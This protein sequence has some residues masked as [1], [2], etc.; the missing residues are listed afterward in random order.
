MTTHEL[1]VYRA[2]PSGQIHL[3]HITRQLSPD[4]VL[5]EVTHASASICGTDSIYLH[6]QQALGHEG[7][8]IVRA[9]GAD[10]RSVRIGDRVGMGYVQKTCGECQSCKSGKRF[11]LIRHALLSV[12]A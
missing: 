3:D 12:V 8:G 11:C 2:S 4:E 6:S 1:Y 7:I 5:V 9:I 10:V